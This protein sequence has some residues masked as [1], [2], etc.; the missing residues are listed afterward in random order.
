MFYSFIKLVQPEIFSGAE[1]Q[2]F[3]KLNLKK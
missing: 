2:F 1:K 3:L